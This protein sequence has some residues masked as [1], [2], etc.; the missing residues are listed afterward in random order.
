MYQFDNS[1]SDVTYHNHD[2]SMTFWINRKLIHWLTIKLFWFCWVCYVSK[3]SKNIKLF[4]AV[5]KKIAKG[6]LRRHFATVFSR[7]K[8]LSPKCSEKITVYQSV[9]NLYQLVKYFLINNQNWIHVV[10]DVTLLVNITPLIVEY[11]LLLDFANRKRLDCSKNNCWVSSK[12][13]KTNCILFALLQV[14][15]STG[16]AKTLSGSDRRRSLWTGSNIKSTNNLNCTQDRQP[17]H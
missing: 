2:V 16:F 5:Q 11:W 8:Q 12:T 7:I 15:E 6:L 9:H 13:V 1:A 3:G 14:I 17:G 10:S 4:R